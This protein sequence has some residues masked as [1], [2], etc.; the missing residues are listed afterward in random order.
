MRWILEF[1]ISSNKENKTGV[2]LLEELLQEKLEKI[3][4]NIS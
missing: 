3:D 2:D 4:R 1:F